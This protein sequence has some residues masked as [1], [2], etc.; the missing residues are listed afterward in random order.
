VS[1]AVERE[2]EALFGT[3]DLPRAGVVHVT[4]AARDPR[5]R[6][7]PLRL[8]AQIPHGETDF[9]VL[10][11]CRARADALLTS[12][13]NLRAEPA[14]RH[15]LVGR[16]GPALAAYRQGTLGKREPP[17]C[18]ILTRSGD[19][20]REHPLW[21][22]PTPKL[23]LSGADQLEA[24]R[25]RWGERA[26]TVGL[27]APSAR[28]ACAF[29]HADGAALISIEAGPNTA[30]TLYDAPPLVDELMLT[31]W[32]D[33][34]PDPALFA[35]PLPE[36]ARLFAGLTLVGSARRVEGGQH[37]HFQRWTRSDR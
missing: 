11:L 28:S 20:P 7:C 2:L 10:S 15:A 22:E 13:Q 33:A 9:F 12:A 35:D 31:L 17:R 19:L 36:D 37:F 18:A 34:P 5:G 14:L 1:A 26:R 23:L 30:A 6:L 21:G 4:F 8:E 27:E 32:E 24:L 16:W 29:L 25:A 3:R